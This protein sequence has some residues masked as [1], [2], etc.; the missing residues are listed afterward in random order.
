MTAS[1]RIREAKRQKLMHEAERNCEWRGHSLDAWVPGDYWVETRTASCKDC[2]MSVSVDPSPP[3]NGIDISGEAVAL[4]CDP[5][6][7]KARL[8]ELRIELRAE[9]ISY[10][11][12]AELESLVKFIEPGDVELLEAAGVPEF[13]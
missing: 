8:E 9:R 13:D 6:V 2:G 12:L 5:S 10:G 11:E 7:P 1:E 4:D 3:A